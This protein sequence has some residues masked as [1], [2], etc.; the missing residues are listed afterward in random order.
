VKQEISA[1]SRSRNACAA[2]ALQEAREML[3]GAQQNEALKKA[4]LLRRNADN[5]GLISSKR[6]GLRK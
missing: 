5:Q 2:D 1:D 6:G 4:G 3:P